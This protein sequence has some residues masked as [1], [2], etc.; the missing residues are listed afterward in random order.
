DNA[1]ELDLRSSVVHFELMKVRC[2][3]LDIAAATDSEENS[4]D[5]AELG[6][7]LAILC[8]SPTALRGAFRCLMLFA[9]RPKSV[10]L[11]P[12]GEASAA[13]RAPSFN[14]LPA[15]TAAQAVRD[16]LRFAELQY[17]REDHATCPSMI[18]HVVVST[19]E[20]LRQAGRQGTG[21]KGGQGRGQRAEGSTEQ[22]GKAKEAESVKFPDFPNPGELASQIIHYKESEA[23]GGRTV[24]EDS[25]DL[26][27][28]IRNWEC[29]IA[30]LTHQPEETTLRDI[31]LRELRASSRLKF[32]LEVYDRA[33]EGDKKHTCDYLVKRVKELL[34]RERTRR[35]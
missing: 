21:G 29:V 32:D 22:E 7:E 1:G 10:P 13:P 11:Y 12:A 33:K 2:G 4:D 19:V 23:S 15:W 17:T 35:N 6:A 14:E 28:F 5:S 18:F 26:S 27:T 24:A 30:G 25:D 34:T 20:K 16:A 8:E 3:C 31:L 9:L